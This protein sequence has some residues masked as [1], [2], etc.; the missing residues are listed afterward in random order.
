MRV[1]ASDL[2]RL[3]KEG[4]GQ[5]GVSDQEARSARLWRAAT[6]QIVIGKEARSPTTARSTRSPTRGDIERPKTRGGRAQ[7]AYC[8]QTVEV[9]KTKPYGSVQVRELVAP[10]LQ[11]A[12]SSAGIFVK[13]LPVSAATGARS[14]FP[15]PNGRREWKPSKKN[16]TL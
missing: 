12:D 1:S 11:P 2:P 16:R 13:R 8:R 10:R 4:S 3:G 9:A 15:F 6:P 5:P 14:D 7:R